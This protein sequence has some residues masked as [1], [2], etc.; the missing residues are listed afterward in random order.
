MNNKGKQRKE[1]DDCCLVC[2][3]EQTRCFYLSQS[4]INEQCIEFGI[5]INMIYI[6]EDVSGKNK[7][8]TEDQLVK[9]NINI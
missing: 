4:S 6:D 8:K 1:L 2:G 7:K 5:H 9:V 3:L